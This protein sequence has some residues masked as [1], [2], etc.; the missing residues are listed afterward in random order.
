MPADSPIASIPELLTERLIRLHYL[1]IGGRT[2]ARWISSGTFPK[3]D[4]SIGMK[5]RFW[6]RETIE[7]WISDR[8]QNGGAR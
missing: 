5:C 1:P 4:L 6:R 2:L 7:R 8:A 3:A